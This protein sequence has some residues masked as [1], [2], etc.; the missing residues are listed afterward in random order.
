MPDYL[1][2]DS[3]GKEESFPGGGFMRN[4]LF[5]SLTVVLICIGV[6]RSQA[7]SLAFASDRSGGRFQ[8]WTAQTSTFTSSLQQVTSAGGGAQ[9][10]R[11]PNWSTTAG[12]I[13]YQFGAPGVRG[14]HTI[15]PD[16]T[17]DVQV[18]PAGAPCGDDSDPSWSHDGTL[19]AY[20]CLNAGHSDIWVHSFASNTESPLVV[21]PPTNQLRPAWSPDGT[22]IAFVSAGPGSQAVINVF[23]VNTHVLHPLTSGTATNFDPAWSPDGTEIAFSS[24]RIGNRHIYTMSVA[25]PEAQSGC[26]AATQLTTAPPNNTRPA[27][28]PD[29]SSIA[30]VSNRIGL[31]QIYVI[32][33]SAQESS[34]NPTTLVSDGTA[35]YE[36]PAWKPAVR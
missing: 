16:G 22:Q 12:K 27:W 15:K 29:G 1:Q 33:P 9:Q 20:A 2:R 25:C 24:T 7:Q 26:P 11:A 4:R 31:D 28:S 35:N 18:T 14:I 32:N 23:N 5:S 34:S 10:N 6:P 36:E 17:G 30:F 3:T 13:A 19:I 8:I 21:L